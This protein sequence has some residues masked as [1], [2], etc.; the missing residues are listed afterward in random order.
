[1]TESFLPPY[2]EEAV[3]DL[4]RRLRETR[5]PETLSVAGS[6]LGMDR[7]SLRACL[8]SSEQQGEEG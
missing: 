6:L 7:E 8:R 2:S 1:M 4:R 3:D 5:W